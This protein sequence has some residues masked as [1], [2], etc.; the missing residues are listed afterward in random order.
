MVNQVPVVSILMIVNGALVSLM[1]LLYSAMGPLMC[2][3]INL[4]PPP[5][6]GGPKPEDKIAFTAISG[7]YIVLGL[8]TLAC[9]ALNIVAGIRGLMFR[10]RIFAL[11]A[12]FCNIITVFTCYCSPISIGVMIY[13]LIVLFQ[14][15]VARAF[16]RV[17]AGMPAERFRHGWD[18]REDD[19][20][21]DEEPEEELPPPPQRPRGGDQIQRA[22]DDGYR[23]PSQ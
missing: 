7:I 15:D 21:Y 12:L 6:P 5:G 3:M 9:G 10:N 11:V 1:G 22:P 14:P 18:P 20:R 19:E 2:T 8:P 13:G 16:A 17:A 23:G 4:A